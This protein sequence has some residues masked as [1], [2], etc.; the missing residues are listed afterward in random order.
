[1]RLPT[2][3]TT[4]D[5]RAI[6][7]RF[8]P[9]RA[10]ARTH[11][12]IV[13]DSSQN[14]ARSSGQLSAPSHRIANTFLAC[15]RSA[16]IRYRNTSYNEQDSRVSPLQASRTTGGFAGGSGGIE[17]FKADLFDGRHWKLSFGLAASASDSLE[18]LGLAVLVTAPVATLGRATSSVTVNVTR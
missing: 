6:W 8:L 9:V 13:G 2:K 12:W 4:E 7:R 17:F 10:A 11:R 15:C 16:G 1:M 3:R 14:H 5:R 18:L